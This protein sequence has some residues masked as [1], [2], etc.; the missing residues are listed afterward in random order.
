MGCEWETNIGD[1]EWGTRKSGVGIK[2]G[3]TKSGRQGKVEWG[4]TWKDVVR[5]EVMVRSVK[6]NSNMIKN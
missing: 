3:G 6:N 4:H 2:S 5:S 1:N